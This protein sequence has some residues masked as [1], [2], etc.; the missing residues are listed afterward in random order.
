LI[1]CCGEF[2]FD[3]GGDQQETEGG[4][5]ANVAFH[6]VRLGFTTGLISRTADDVRGERLRVWLERVGIGVEA[7]VSGAPAPTGIVKVSAGADG[8]VYDICAPAAWDFLEA[9]PLAMAKA[10]RSRVLVCG[11]LAQ[12]H[13][14]ARMAVRRLAGVA[15]ASGAAVLVDL[16]LRA[17]FFDE[18]VVLW[19]LRN[20]DVLKLTV[21]ELATVSAMLGACGGREELF[22]GLVREFGFS[23]AVLT[24]GVE[25]AWF[26]EEGLTWHQP[27]VPVSAIDTVGCGDAVTAVVAAALVS[28]RS[29]REA[30]PC[31]MEVA[32]F[33]ATQPGA[34]PPW[35]DDL[36]LRARAMLSAQG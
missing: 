15:R 12:R 13:P 2:L 22:L 26:Y 10:E 32:G 19:S 30:A 8:P 27:S 34:T 14:V 24:A 33:V 36:V 35:P 5:P 16:N 21:D 6:A 4:A 31:C 1:C 28:G 25:G 17:P 9:D 20:A 18:E 11:T 29:L 23:R 7:I 3:C